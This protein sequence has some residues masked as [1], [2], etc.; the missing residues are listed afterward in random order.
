MS[1]G[2]RAEW[3]PIRS[4]FDLNQLE[5]LFLRSFLDQPKPENS[6]RRPRISAPRS[7][8]ELSESDMKFFTQQL[9][10]PYLQRN[11]QGEPFE[12]FPAGCRGMN[13]HRC[14]AFME[15]CQGVCSSCGTLCQS[16]EGPCKACLDVCETCNKPRY[17]CASTEKRSEQTAQEEKM[18]IDSEGMM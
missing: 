15:E 13:C 12:E 1:H 14:G 16:S 4:V 5:I 7:E 10:A 6:P 3:S 8:D 9:Q 18:C 11:K 2:N 17:R